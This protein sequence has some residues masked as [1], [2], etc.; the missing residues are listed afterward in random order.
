MSEENQASA[1]APSTVMIHNVSLEQFERAVYQRKHE[2]ASQLL[3]QALRRIKIGGVFIGYPPVPDL[4]RQLYTRFCSAVIAMLADPLFSISQDGLDTFASEH[5][6]MDVCF[7]Q[8]AYGTSDHLLAQLATMPGEEVDVRKLR[9]ENGASLVKFLV[10]YSLRSSFD[11]DFEATFKKQPQLI[12][13]LWAGMLSA[14]LTIHPKAQERHEFLLGLHHLFADVIPSPAVLPSLSDAYMYTSY[15][16]RSDKHDAKATIHRI[17]ARFL[18]HHQVAM[19]RIDRVLGR[20]KIKDRRDK[21]VILVCC[22]WF[23]SQHAMYRC[24]APII[25][26]LRDRFYLVGMSRSTD[27]DDI[28][29]ATFDE[30]REVPSENLILAK[31]IAEVT[32]IAPD[33][34]Y[35]PSLGMALWWV[36]LASVRL[37]PIQF[38]T[39]GHPAS[40]RS[41]C[42][43]YVVCEE[44]AIAEPEL[45]SEKVVTMPFGSA[46]YVMRTDAVLPEPLREDL[47]A[48]VRV[49]VPAMLCKLNARFMDALREIDQRVKRTNRDFGSPAPQVEFHFFINMA[50][51]NLHQGAAEIREY[52]P[53]ALIYE[54]AHYSQYMDH[55]RRCHLHLGTFPFGGTNSN[56]DSMLLG[57]PVLAMEGKEP[58]ERFDAMQLR[59]VGLDDWLVASNVPDYIERA[60]DLIVDH[61]KRQSLRDQ[62]LATD[63]RALFYGQPRPHAV[64]GFLAAVETIFEQHEEI[65]AS[66]NRMFRTAPGVVGAMAPAL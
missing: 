9:F 21:P 32:E 25:K 49:A 56:V 50:G 43:D 35:Y 23:G 57:I 53:T 54:R 58:H 39:L 4:Y 8:S 46:R 62:L 14:L 36:V 48:V 1:I 31:L 15:A 18:D 38:M 19:P 7:R 33:M 47:P 52:L 45:F 34:I 59:H 63:L 11:M 27:I 6:I 10:T 64:G 16:L 3:V 61:H 24:Y 66:G 2:E 65:Q 51:A 55:L 28:G 44:G 12:F 37:A 22:E 17:F 13:S 41:P 30:W 42:M 26:Q 5:A 29:K 40:S 60:V 20:R